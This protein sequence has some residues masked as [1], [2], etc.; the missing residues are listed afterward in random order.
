MKLRLLGELNDFIARSQRGRTQTVAL[1]RRAGVKDVIEARGVPHT[2]IGLVRID[3]L[4]APLAS[5]LAPGSAAHIVAAPMTPAQRRAD[6]PGAAPAFVADVH[7]GTLVRRLRLA[8]FDVAYANDC[9]D[10]GLAAISDETD[11]VLLTRDRGLLKRARVRHARF[12]RDDA[13]Q[14]QYDDIVA[15][16]SLTDRMQ[17]FTRCSDCNTPLAAVAKADIVHRLEPL[18]KAHYHRFA[19]CPACDKL[20]WGGSHVADMRGRL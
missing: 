7:L 12:V 18:T 17:P 14:A 11:R 4:A 13:P 2:E 15:H 3:G 16:F 9:D 19:R 5:V 8:G 20:F 1:S 10:A 6:W